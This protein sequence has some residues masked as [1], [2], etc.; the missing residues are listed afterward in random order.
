MKAKGIKLTFNSGY[1]YKDIATTD[2]W[3]AAVSTAK[4]A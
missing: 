1:S 2:W 4:K 3:A